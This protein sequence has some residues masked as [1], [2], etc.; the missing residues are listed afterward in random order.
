[1]NRGNIHWLPLGQVSS[2]SLAEA[3]AQLHHAVQFIAMAGKYL[4]PEKSD[5][6]HTAMRWRPERHSYIGDLVEAPVPF[7]VALQSLRFNLLILDEEMRK[8]NE[9]HLPGV[10][11]GYAFAWLREQVVA[12][13]IDHTLL[14]KKMHY[15]IPEHPID[16][17]SPYRI[18][19]PEAFRQI[20]KLRTNAELLLDNLSRKYKNASEVRVWPHHFDS[21]LFIPFDEEVSKSMGIGLAIADDL[22]DEPYLYVSLW[23]KDG[24]KLPASMPQLTD[25]SWQSSSFKGAVL[26][27]S[28]LSSNE[29]P[30]V[31]SEIAER[32][33]IE[34]TNSL[35]EVLKED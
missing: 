8:I 9:L 20:A 29:D 21:G 24:I 28:T 7:R 1:M 26:T 6:S 4:T 31:Q 25:G 32:F 27:Y 18:S 13:G 15:T 12:L 22:I 19:N 34:A 11:H 2:K 10:T 35:W 14:K 3:N 5:D 17:C 30:K 33:L 23:S 16:K